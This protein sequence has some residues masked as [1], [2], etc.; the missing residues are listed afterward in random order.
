MKHIVIAI[1]GPAASGKSTLTN[2]LARHMGY[3]AVN[4]G[5]FYRLVTWAVLEAGIDPVDACAVEGFASELEFQIDG[6]EGDLRITLEGMA[7]DPDIRSESVNAAVSKI[8]AYKSVRDHVTAG[9]RSLADRWD[10]VIEGRDIGTAVFPDT[11][12]KIY[13]DAPV[14][15]RSARRAAQGEVDNPAARDAADSSRALAPLSIARDATVIDVSSKT[16]EE[17]VDA[18]LEA[19]SARGLKTTIMAAPSAMLSFSLVL[20]QMVQSALGTYA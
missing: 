18:A 17:V 1:D 4:S 5:V 15:V 13:L 10:C 19:L 7:D 16:R 8:S 14:G 9:L 20:A 3:A 12:H 6:Q 2:R 11:P